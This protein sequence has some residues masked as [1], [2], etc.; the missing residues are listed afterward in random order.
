VTINEWLCFDR[1]GR[2]TVTAVS[3]IV[4]LDGAGELN[5]GPIVPLEGEPLEIAIVPSD[6]RRRLDRIARARTALGGD[7]RGARGEG[8]ARGSDRDPDSRGPDA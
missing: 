4:H 3:R 5:G 2:Y 1:P 8:H 7:D 6:D